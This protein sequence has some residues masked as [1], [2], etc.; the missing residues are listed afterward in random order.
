[1]LKS[2]DDPLDQHVSSITISSSTHTHP[3]PVPAPPQPPLPTAN[4]DLPSL[5]AV[6]LDARDIPPVE[7]Q[8]LPHPAPDTNFAYSYPPPPGEDNSGAL[9]YPLETPHLTR[10]PVAVLCKDPAVGRGVFATADI[11]AGEVVEVSPVLVLGEKEYKGTTA[12]ESP[13]DGKLRGV[14]ASQL[15]GYV[16][17]WGR[18]GSMAVALGLGSLFNH[19]STPNVS[20]SLDH[21]QYTISYRAAKPIQAGEELCIFYGHSVSFANSASSGAA[22]N[23]VES[24]DDGWGGLGAVG[25]EAG[26]D[27]REEEED[28]PEELKRIKALKKLTPEELDERDTE[29]VGFDEE[30]FNWKRVTDIIDPE[31]AV[32]S[33]MPCYAITIAA[34]HSALVF[35]FVRKHSN[36]K[37]NELGHLKR[38]KP[39]AVPAPIPAQAEAVAEGAH[40]EP[41]P[42]RTETTGADAQQHVLLWPVASAPPNLRE[43]LSASPIA[44]ALAASNP[45]A[46]PDALAAL[47]EPFVVDVPAQAAHTEEQATEWGKVWP[48]TVVHIREGAKATRRKRGWERAKLEWIEREARKVWNRADEAARLGEHPIAC[49][50][51]DTWY[52]GFH[53]SLRPPLVVVNAL[54][55]RKS[56]GNV[57]AH[58]ACNAIDAVAVLDLHDARPPL[59]RFNPE[60]ADPPYLLNGLTLFISHEPCL[61]C[62]MSLLHSRV[63]QVYFVKRAPGAG[64]CGSLYNVHED[65]G[66]N[67][68]FEV[69]EWTGPRDRGMAEGEPDR[70]RM[71]P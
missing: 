57:L 36:R 61:L 3:L 11:P 6:A 35:Q 33:T 22:A 65:G 56:T 40:V 13:D 15:R 38:V 43:L 42:A 8:Q 18:D 66:L 51:T 59:S 7:Q 69:W 28:T 44:A 68:R 64:G 4:P 37:F 63:K 21:A 14:E 70:L 55:T 41:V 52:P 2:P 46:S 62:A 30:G 53:T 29:I 9:P 10:A 26:Q 34:R 31:D 67:H 50:V 25:S 1:M 16:F 12:G 48:V 17:T 5:A 19:S 58:A 24:V 47:L 23:D 45:T 32:L 71:D 60:A 54:D 20:Y 49:H 39:L 27:E